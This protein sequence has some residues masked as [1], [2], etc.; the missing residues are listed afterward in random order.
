VRVPA[1][2]GADIPVR[3]GPVP[4]VHLSYPFVLEVDGRLYC[5]PESNQAREIVLYELERF[6]DR[7]KKVAT[8]VSDCVMVDATLFR[9]EE[10]WW[11][12]AT[13]DSK[14]GDNSALH[15][16]YATDIAGPWQAHPGN[17]VKVDVRSARPAGTPFVHEGKLYRPAQDCS[18]TYGGRTVINRVVTLTRTAFEEEFAVAVE[19][20]VSG[21]YPR[22]LHTIS[23]VGAI[24]LIDGKRTRFVPEQFWRTLR[25]WLQRPL[26]RRHRS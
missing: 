4:P 19:P 17:P 24:T 23:A 20:D 11:I 14:R 22:G 10:S 5:L 8:L 15:L 18:K 25:G 1:G 16:W 9:H 2:A 7:W 3:I 6:P 26:R 12:A 21:P 13:D